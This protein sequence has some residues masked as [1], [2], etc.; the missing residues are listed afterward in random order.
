MIVDT[1]LFFTESAH[2]AAKV[3]RDVLLPLQPEE[4]SANHHEQH[5]TLE[6]QDAPQ[7]RSERIDLQ[8]KS[9]HKTI[10]LFVSYEIE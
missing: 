1:I 8:K 10:Y 5:P 3:L 9:T 7:V 4:H 6:H 2:V